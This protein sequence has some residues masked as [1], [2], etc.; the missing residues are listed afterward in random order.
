MRMEHAKHI[1]ARLVNLRMD[2]P[3]ANRA[4][5][6]R[7]CIHTLAVE[8]DD[9]QVFRSQPAP[10]HRPGFNEDS[11]LVE[12]G[13]QMS[14]QSIS[15]SLNG[16]EDFARFYEPFTEIPFNSCCCR[17]HLDLCF[18]QVARAL[19]ELHITLQEQ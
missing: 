2:R 6:A 14:A 5:F 11:L 7:G 17:I 12:P 18:H 9:D 3:L 19:V 13:T 8:V 15:R 16:V 1:G 10:A 4:A